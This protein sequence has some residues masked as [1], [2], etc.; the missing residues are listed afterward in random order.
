MFLVEEDSIPL[1]SETVKKAAREAIVAVARRPVHD[2]QRV[3]STGMIDSPLGAQTDRHSGDEI[4]DLDF[5]DQVQPED[6]DSVEMILDTLERVA[7]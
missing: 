6:F 1:D 4:T 2:E 7:Q 3:V 5:E